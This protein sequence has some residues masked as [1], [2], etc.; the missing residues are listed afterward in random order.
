[1]LPGTQEVEEL[2]VIPQWKIFEMLDSNNFSLILVQ[3]E[4]LFRAAD[5]LYHTILA[6][7][8]I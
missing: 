1:M 8:R 3:E 2:N 7:R 5:V 4:P 6:Q